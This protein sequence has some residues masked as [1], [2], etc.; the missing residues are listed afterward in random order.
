MNLDYEL[1]DGYTLEDYG[2]Y[3]EEG[4][5]H[6]YGGWH[7]TVYENPA[8]LN[9]WFDFITPSGYLN[10]FSIDNIGVKGKYLNDSKIKSIAYKKPPAIKI[11]SSMDWELLGDNPDPS[12]SY[13]QLGGLLE[14]A[15]SV[16]T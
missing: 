14:N 7:K 9:F 13:I 11:L 6:N 4:S 8:G 15:Y 1:P 2:Y 12:Y 3:D 10:K 16:S 5:F